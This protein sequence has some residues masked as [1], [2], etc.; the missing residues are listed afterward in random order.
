MGDKPVCQNCSG[1]IELPFYV[2]KTTMKWYCKECEF[3]KIE[4]AE[5]EYC[6]LRLTED[7]HEH[8]CIKEVQEEEKENERNTKM[9]SKEDNSPN[10]SEKP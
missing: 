1:M 10:L 7:H 9:E 8:I 6:R 4:K 5:D 2:C 3:S